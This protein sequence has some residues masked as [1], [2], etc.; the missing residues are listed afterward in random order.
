MYSIYVYSYCVDCTVGTDLGHSMDGRKCLFQLAGRRAAAVSA[1]AKEC[2]ITP[3]SYRR[4]TGSSSR[5]KTSVPSARLAA[6]SLSSAH[7]SKSAPRWDPVI[8]AEPM[9]AEKPLARRPS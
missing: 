1:A 7:G 4:C 3:F 8:E 6:A 9:P 5:C 2:W